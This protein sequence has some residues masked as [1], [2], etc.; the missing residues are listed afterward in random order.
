MTS[1]KKIGT[2]LWQSREKCVIPLVQLVNEGIHP[3]IKN[4][5]P[6]SHH[7][8]LTD[9]FCVMGERGWEEKG[10]AGNEL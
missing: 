5:S 8:V 6:F 7:Q 1:Q 9:H 4:N 2:F 3:K 10:P